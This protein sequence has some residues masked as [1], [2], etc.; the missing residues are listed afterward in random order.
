[1]RHLN[2]NNKILWSNKEFIRESKKKKK[3][4]KLEKSL[5]RFP[6]TMEDKGKCI[7]VVS[8]LKWARAGQDK[9]LSLCFSTFFL[10]LSQSKGLTFESA[11]TECSRRR[12]VSPCSPWNHHSVCIT[13]TCWARPCP[14]PT[15]ESSPC[16]PHLPICF[17]PPPFLT[18]SRKE[19]RLATKT[20]VPSLTS[21]PT[22]LPL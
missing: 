8:V 2:A 6:F 20:H 15:P 4:K 17:S 21:S 9:V 5:Y 13:A 19:N 10:L 11:P 3:K 16:S 22:F 14:P 1:M 18:Q 12:R 7:H